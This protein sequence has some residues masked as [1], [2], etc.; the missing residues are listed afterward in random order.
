MV[1]TAF[2]RNLRVIGALS[3]QRRITA[4]VLYRSYTMKRMMIAATI[5]AL[6][7][8]VAFAA[9]DIADIDIDGDGLVSEAEL[10]TAYPKFDKNFFG[11]IDMNDDG[12]LDSDELYAIPAQNAIARATADN[13]TLMADIDGDGFVTLE[14]LTTIVPGFSN[15]DFDS[16]DTND[17]NRLTAV[18]MSA[19]GASALING[20]TAVEMAVQMDVLDTDKDQFLTYSELLAGF[21]DVPQVGFDDIDTNDDNRVS[22][23]EYY[24]D[25]ARNML[26]QY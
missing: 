18:E 12:R 8:S 23:K 11:D 7:T 6:S 19:E 3:V 20:E 9:T 14:E 2:A 4:P 17:D 10:Y 16:L 1:K 24:S 25:G 13:S 21:P 26:N 5:A 15:I 22:S